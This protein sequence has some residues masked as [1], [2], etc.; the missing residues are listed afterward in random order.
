VRGWRGRLPKLEQA[1]RAGVQLIS[2]QNCFLLL[3]QQFAVSPGQFVIAI[4]TMSLGLLL[5]L[6]LLL[7]SHSLE[8]KAN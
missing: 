5:L 1:S 2:L 8:V 7:F 6:Q 3:Q 4:V